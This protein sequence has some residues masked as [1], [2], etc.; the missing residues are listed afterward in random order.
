MFLYGLSTYSIILLTTALINLILAIYA[1]RF[2]KSPG[3]LAYCL[4][5]VCTSIY[6]FGYAFEIK[7]D[8]LQKIKFWVDF[9]FLGISFL[10]TVL[11]ILAMQ[12]TGWGHLLKSWLVALLVT[13]STITLILQYTNYNNLFYEEIKLNAT[14]PIP[15]ADFKMGIWFWIFQIFMNFILL[16]SCLLYLLMV[17]ESKGTNR[18][19][20]SVMLFSL[21]I[22]WTV[23]FIYLSGK[24]PYNIELSPF[25]F[26]IVGILGALGI[27]RYH[28]FE[29]VPLALENVFNSMTDG[30]IILDSKKHLVNYNNSAKKI[31]MPA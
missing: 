8:S 3:T 20:A 15:L 10:P 19:R 14:A 2:I 29:F 13:F 21:V 27:F 30:V 28:L 7:A 9:E 18:M 22:P 26:S 11:I 31:K 24:S 16:M 17:I 4:L 5:L 12:Y 25:S 1:L 6:S 23:Y